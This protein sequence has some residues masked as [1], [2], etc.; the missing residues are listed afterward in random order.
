LG[1]LRAIAKSY[2]IV[3]EVQEK[4]K[5]RWFFINFVQRLHSRIPPPALALRVG[6]WRRL[7]LSALLKVFFIL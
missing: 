4:Q 3:V 2:S 5:N 7:A 1:N 6:F